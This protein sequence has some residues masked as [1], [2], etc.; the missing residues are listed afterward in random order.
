MLKFNFKYKKFFLC[1][2]AK[3]D[4]EDFVLVASLQSLVYPE[5]TPIDD[6]FDFT[7]TAGRAM[8]Q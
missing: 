1:V 2:L 4:S 6:A 5:H 3:N 7:R 8:M